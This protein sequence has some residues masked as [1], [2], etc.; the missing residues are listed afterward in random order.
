[1]RVLEPTVTVTHT[2]GDTTPGVNSNLKFIK[3]FPGTT[4]SLGLN[5]IKYILH[6]TRPGTIPLIQYERNNL[7]LG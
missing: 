4:C 1:M 3:H 5:I 7:G 2:R 6:Y